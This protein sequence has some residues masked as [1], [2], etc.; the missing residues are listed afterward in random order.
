MKK[1]ISLFEMLKMTYKQ[2][3]TSYGEA[4]IKVK[5]K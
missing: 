4:I 5:V 2:S 1:C 3:M